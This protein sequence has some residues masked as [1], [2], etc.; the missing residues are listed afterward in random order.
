MAPG[1]FHAS[2]GPGKDDACSHGGEKLS[3]APKSLRGQDEPCCLLRLG[4]RSCAVPPRAYPGG[5][6][7]FQPSLWQQDTLSSASLCLG[8]APPSPLF[9]RQPHTVLGLGRVG[10]ESKRLR[11]G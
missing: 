8:A 9:P 2:T 5:Q 3:I 11:A 10:E 7:S 1:S 6:S 4:S